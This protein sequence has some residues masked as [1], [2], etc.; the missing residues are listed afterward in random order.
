ML[1]GALSVLPCGPLACR[2]F[3]ELVIEFWVG[4]TDDAVVIEI[5]GKVFGNV[6]MVRER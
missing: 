3:R 4:E 1:V 2:R 6:C 5:V